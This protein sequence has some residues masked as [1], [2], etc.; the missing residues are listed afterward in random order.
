[1]KR[2]LIMASVVLAGTTA[3]A[4][5]K[6]VTVEMKNAEGASVGRAKITGTGKSLQIQ[7]DFKNLPPG[8]HAIHVHETAKCDGPDFKSAGAHLNPQKKQHGFENPKGPH[9]GDA[10]NFEVK[11]DGTSKDTVRAKNLSAKDR[12]LLFLGGGT[13]LVIHEKAD[14]YRTDPSGNSGARIAC[15]VI[16]PQ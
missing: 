15:G 4:Q 3:I 9:K 14:D 5:N 6:P 10:T 8:T 11:Q 7:L 12:K 2:L 16:L 1:M 13:S